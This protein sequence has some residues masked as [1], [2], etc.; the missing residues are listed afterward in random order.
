MRNFFLFIIILFSYLTHSQAQFIPYKH[1]SRHPIGD[2]IYDNQTITENNDDDNGMCHL[3]V[4]CPAVPAL[5]KFLSLFFTFYLSFIFILDPYDQ[6]GRNRRFSVD[7]FLAM[8]GPPGPPGVPGP[9]GNPGPRGA[10]GPQGIV[11]R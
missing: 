8:H 9:Q 10:V 7:N 11:F 4:R 1:Y 3:T 2:T 6:D 5:C